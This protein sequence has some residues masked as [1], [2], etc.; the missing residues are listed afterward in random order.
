MCCVLC[1]V[2][3][4]WTS[5][6]SKNISSALHLGQSVSVFVPRNYNLTQD[7]NWININS[8][9]IGSKLEPNK[10]LGSLDRIKE[11]LFK[12][13]EYHAEDY[14][15]FRLSQDPILMTKNYQDAH[16]C[17]PH[18]QLSVNNNFLS[19]HSPKDQSQLVEFGN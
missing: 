16:V 9:Y 13:N 7:L 3:N 10:S 1:F 6:F 17:Y 4:V 5:S 18:C 12:H 19:Q 15:K 11:W 2:V 14:I 8:L